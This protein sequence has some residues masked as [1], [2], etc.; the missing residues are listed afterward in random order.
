[1]D[2]AAWRDADLPGQLL[3]CLEKNRQHVKWNDQYAL[4]VVLAGRWGQLDVRWNQGTHIF[5]YPTW[6]QSPFDRE[7]FEKLRNDPYLIHF[8]TRDKPWMVSCPHPS[9]E[10][11][12]AFLDRTAWAG[13]RP[14]AISHLRAAYDR[15]RAHQRRFRHARKQLQS[16]AMNWVYQRCG[17]AAR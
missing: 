11:F 6:F 1:V 17:V 10:L 14:S 8:T 3:T 12:Y 16:R 15:L 7:T 9:R 13:W 5:G 2:F 4:N